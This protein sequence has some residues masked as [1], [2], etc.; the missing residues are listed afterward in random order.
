MLPNMDTNIS[1]PF[2]VERF[3]RTRRGIRR[4]FDLYQDQG[5]HLEQ[6]KTD[7][8]CIAEVEEIISEALVV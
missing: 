4:D 8:T 1:P 2:M 6:K 7:S 5:K 3:K